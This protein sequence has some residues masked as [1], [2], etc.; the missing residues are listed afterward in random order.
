MPFGKTYAEIKEMIED[1]VLYVPMARA[2]LRR[3]GW[4][5]GFGID[6]ELA[7]PILNLKPRNEPPSPFPDDD[8]SNQLGWKF[9]LT[10]LEE[11]IDGAESRNY[12]FGNDWFVFR[13]DL[14]NATEI[15]MSASA[16]DAIDVPAGAYLSVEVALDS[17]P[18][19]WRYPAGTNTTPFVVLDDAIFVTSP[20]ATIDAE[21]NTDLTMRIRM[22]GYTSFTQFSPNQILVEVR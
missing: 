3:S 16:F 5:P 7:V 12:P 15:R 22:N 13:V 11:I 21:C 18:G 8:P 9:I 10:R 6:A 20:W 14:S 17:D 2:I 4:R 1:I 19:T